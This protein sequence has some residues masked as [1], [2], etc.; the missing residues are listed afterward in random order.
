MVVSGIQSWLRSKTDYMCNIISGW[1]MSEFHPD[2][3]QYTNKNRHG[4]C[5]IIQDDGMYWWNIRMTSWWWEDK[6]SNETKNIAERLWCLAYFL[7]AN[8]LT[9]KEIA[10]RSLK[11]NTNAIIPTEIWISALYVSRAAPQ[12]QGSKVMIRLLLLHHQCLHHQS[13]PHAPI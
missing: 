7:K 4:W 9:P 11:G 8:I 1:K 2:L 3:V 10:P 6:C 5:L 12:F 13:T